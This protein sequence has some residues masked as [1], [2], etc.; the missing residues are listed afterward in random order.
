VATAAL[1]IGVALARAGSDRRVEHRRRRD[2]KLGLAPGEPLEEG[3]RRMAVA[4]A[5]LAIDQLQGDGGA[6]EAIHESRKAIKRIRT[7]VRMLE[8]EL[9]AGASKREQDALRGTAARL[10]GVRDAE[11]MLDTLELM[12]REHPRKLA[13]RKGVARLRARL[14][15][16]R[17]LARREAGDGAVRMLAAEDLHAFTLRAQSWPL[18]A[19]PGIGA[20][21]VG[22]RRVYRQGRRR[23]KRAS[24]PQGGSM[25]TMHQLRKRVKDVRYVAEALRR[26]PGPTAVLHRSATAKGARKQARW[27]TRLAGRADALGELLGEEH[28]L[29]VLGLWLESHEARKSAGAGTRRRLRKRIA[30]RRGRLRRQALRDGRRLYG[31]H[32]GAFV[33]RIGRAYERAGLL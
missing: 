23:F 32:A 30:R 9:G 12:V 18:H 24:G 10:A 26:E 22:L 17:E 25:R 31:R 1:T 15:A 27:L 19:S 4:Q 16:K 21:E 6:I 11:V 13:G 8:S 14:I 33:A 20:V 29:A 5:E 28:D 7:I 2:G 3:L